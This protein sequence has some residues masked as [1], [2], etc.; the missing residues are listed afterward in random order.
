MGKKES[1]PK[2]EYTEEFKAEAVKPGMSI[3]GNAAAKRLGIPHIAAFWPI[4]A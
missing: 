2:R 3:G 1:V 4:T